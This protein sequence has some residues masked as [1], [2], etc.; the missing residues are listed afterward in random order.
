M[1]V[2][3]LGP[4]D[5]AIPDN[6]GIVEHP[7]HLIFARCDTLVEVGDERPEQQMAVR[8]LDMVQVTTT[9]QPRQPQRLQ[10]QPL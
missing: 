5:D 7:R 9:P 6:V 4:G 8:R 10:Q 1:V 2:E 3:E